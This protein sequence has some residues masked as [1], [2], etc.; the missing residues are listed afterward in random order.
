MA[1]YP[2]HQGTTLYET[3]A[4][5]GYRFRIQ[6]PI[7]QGG[8]GI[9]YL[10]EDLE[11]QGPCVIKEFA[12]GELCARSDAT[13]S[14]T[15]A[16]GRKPDFDRWLERFES[17]ARLIHCI[18]HANV[19]RVRAV[20]QERGTAYYAMD[21]ITGAGELP[22]PDEEGW[23]PMSWPEAERIASAM[24]SALSEVH[25][26]GLIH[27]DIKPSN[28]LLDTKGQPILIDFG[29]ARS[30]D[31]LQRTV[32]SAPHTP[33]YAPPELTVRSRVHRAGPWSD[34]YSWAM[35]VWGLV[36]RHHGLDGLPLDAGSRMAVAQSGGTDRYLSGA[37]SLLAAG[38]PAR[39]ANALQ[40]CLE[41]EPGHRPA[42]CDAVQLMVR[43]SSDKRTAPATVLEVPASTEATGP[44]PSSTG[45][46]SVGS[47]GAGR[48]AA[49]AE[50]NG[51]AADGPSSD[52]PSPSP[53]WRRRVVPL[54]LACVAVGLV[55]AGL[56]GAR[57]SEGS[58]RG[59]GMVLD[60]AETAVYAEPDAT[61]PAHPVA[62]TTVDAAAP[63]A[64]EASSAFPTATSAD[65]GT[66]TPAALET[67]TG[68]VLVPA[69]S[70]M[71][72]SPAGEPWR[73]R[74]ELQH[75]VQL[76]RSFW[77]SVNEA[78]Q[79]E[80]WELMQRNPSG[81]PA[82]GSECPVEKV[83]WFDAIEFANA[84][85]EAEGFPPCYDASG[86]VT[87][88]DSVYDCQG[89]RLPTEAEW[90]YAARAGT[91][92]AVYGPLNDIAW[93]MANSRRG[94]RPVRQKL[95]NRWGLYDMMGN[96]KEWTH[97]RRLAYSAGNLRDP[98]GVSA[99][100]RQVFRGCG[101][102]SG[103]M[104]CRVAVRYGENSMRRANSIGFR[105]A[106]TAP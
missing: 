66:E 68:M 5:S 29:T 72:G 57:E 15:V 56:S 97:D 22:S 77:L 21:L 53:S 75:E 79:A 46:S 3:R 20:W 99:S 36:A 91:S 8:F 43:A 89:Y 60:V 50:A 42:S 19:V 82:C 51:M 7:G 17:E 45:S 54:I 47:A 1:I 14:L 83:T 85:S 67:P 30:S 28:V 6:R 24:L 44:R 86:N 103:A 106:R 4:G 100:E 10:A 62:R 84:R 49:V 94:T 18:R 80:Y 81:F 13:G 95:P 74:D 32:T 88:V 59:M 25:E 34:L 11:F 61:G 16:P 33:G 26:Q 70:F 27:G 92:D 41:L 31:E 105:L 38:V 12:L 2:L 65:A 23:R 9:T 73:D 71:M 48:G 98:V 78:T 40:A 69:G 39:W 64:V 101:W 102:N 35:V 87:G 37:A 58:G 90:E 63:E 55:V 93:Y 52:R 96:V 104:F 76:T